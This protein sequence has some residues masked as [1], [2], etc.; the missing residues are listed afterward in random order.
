[1]RVT[2]TRMIELAGDAVSQARDRAAAAGEVMSGGLRVTLPSDG[3]GAWADGIR[4]EIRSRL[5]DHRGSAVARARDGLIAADRSL[6]VVGGALSS[7]S[8]LALQMA[9]GT[10]SA[11]ERKSGAIAIRALREQA[12][13]AANGRGVDGEH[14]FAGSL[15]DAPPFSPGGVYAGDLVVRQIET[16][17]GLSQT[18]TLSGA[19]LTAAS[20]VDVF[21]VLDDLATALDA[22]DVAGVKTAIGGLNLA[23]GQVARTRSEVGTRISALDGAEESRRALVVHL[24]EIHARAVEADP[25]AAASALASAKVGL[26]GARAVAEQ[27]IAMTRPT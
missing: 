16:F 12:I 13:A 5:A 24:A 9:N 26:E 8:E 20:G 21:K 3:P 27:I 7:A 18:V 23:I 6:E 2:E 25:V 22:N 10:L 19:V 15:G 14:L 17:D 4:A 11:D 1:M